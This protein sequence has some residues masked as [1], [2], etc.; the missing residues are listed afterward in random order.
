MKNFHQKGD[1]IVVDAPSGGV[2]SGDG[3][4][5]GSVFGV[6]EHDAAEEA[7]VVLVLTGVY[8]LPKTS[9]QAWTQGAPIYWDNTQK[10]CTSVF[11][12]N[13]LIGVAWEAAGNPSDFG[14]VRLNSTFGVVSKAYV[15][16]G[17]A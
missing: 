1:R 3:V 16:A 13:T 9:A 17:D 8:E 7:P 6:A 14:L 10:E 4:L 2:S 15:D 5:S 11:T 12:G